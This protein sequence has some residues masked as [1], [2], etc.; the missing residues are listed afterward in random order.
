MTALVSK[1]ENDVIGWNLAQTLLIRKFRAAGSLII[2]FVGL[3]IDS[4]I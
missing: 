2:R 1:D 4:L 3:K